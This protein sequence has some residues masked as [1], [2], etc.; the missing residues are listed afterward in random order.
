MKGLTM[1]ITPKH[2]EL[3]FELSHIQTKKERHT[4]TELYKIADKLLKQY[5]FSFISHELANLAQESGL[6]NVDVFLKR[7]YPKS[8]YGEKCKITNPKI[9]SIIKKI[10]GWN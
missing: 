3:I 7:R 10:K 2:K 1:N 6:K 9:L 5:D 8:Y 4:Y